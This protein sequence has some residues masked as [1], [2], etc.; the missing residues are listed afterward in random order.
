M[1]K[2]TDQVVSL[3]ERCYSIDTESRQLHNYAT[4][5]IDSIRITDIATCPQILESTQESKIISQTRFPNDS[6]LY[7]ALLS[8]IR[9]DS[10]STQII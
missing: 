3:I 9:S 1:K 10:E 8:Y 5:D 7:I 4:G 6:E 2:Q